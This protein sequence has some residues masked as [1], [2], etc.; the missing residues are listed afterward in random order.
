[1]TSQNPTLPLG[2]RGAGDILGLEDAARGDTAVGSAAE[3]MIAQVII[4]DVIAGLMEGLVVGAGR[5]P[6]RSG[7]RP[8]GPA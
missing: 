6:G 7:A 8:F 4:Q 2:G 3:T 5:T 1:M